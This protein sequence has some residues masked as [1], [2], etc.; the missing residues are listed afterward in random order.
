MVAYAPVLSDAQ[1]RSVE[2]LN[3]AIEAQGDQ[4][5]ARADGGLLPATRSTTPSTPPANSPTARRLQHWTLE[6]G[7]AQL[8]S[9]GAEQDLATPSVDRDM[10]A[11]SRRR[12]DPARRELAATSTT[13]A[14]TT[15]SQWVDEHKE[16]LDD[17]RHRAGA[18]AA[19][20]GAILLFV[21]GLNIIVV[22][23]SPSSC[24]ANIAFQAFNGVAQVPTG[25][26]SLAEAIVN[27]GL[28]VLNVVG[29][30]CGPQVARPAT[31]ATVATSLMRSF[32]AGASPA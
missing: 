27:V 5:Y 12:G 17:D 21:P 19:I 4:A 30:R 32:A 15:S 22:G 6:S 13:A 16:I 24:I 10:A 28:A 23:S 1:A 14:G 7:G 11:E 25:N 2:A 20:A 9:R 3:E 8:S 31:K 29:A 26:M 18:I